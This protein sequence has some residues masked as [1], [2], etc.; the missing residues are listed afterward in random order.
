M[1]IQQHLVLSILP[2]VDQILALKLLWGRQK[3]HCMPVNDFSV[4]QGNLTARA[5]AQS[6]EEKGPDLYA[7]ESL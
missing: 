3:V 2:L 6:V 7:N 4:T 5:R 1:G